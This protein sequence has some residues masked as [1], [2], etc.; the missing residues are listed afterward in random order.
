MGLRNLHVFFFFFFFGLGKSGYFW[1]YWP[2]AGIFWVTFK[3]DYFLG[4]LY[5]NSRYFF[6][7][8]FFFFLVVVEV[9]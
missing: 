9:W 7:F 8:F 1:G 2:F 5:Q 3:T 4:L 6:F